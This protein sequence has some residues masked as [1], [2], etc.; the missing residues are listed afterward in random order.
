MHG[1][2][3]THFTASAMNYLQHRGEGRKA[4]LAAS[5]ERHKAMM[6]GEPTE[7]RGE[8]NQVLMCVCEAT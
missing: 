5:W 2:W 7:L 6:Q 1:A 4:T 3:P 8:T